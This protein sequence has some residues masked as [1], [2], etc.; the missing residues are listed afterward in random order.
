MYQIYDRGRNAAR[1]SIQE[2][3]GINKKIRPSES[4][5]ADARNLSAREYPALVTRE[6]REYITD[7]GRCISPSLCA[8]GDGNVAHFLQDDEGKH[9]AINGKK[10]F[11]LEPSGAIR[12]LVKM[13]AYLCVFP[14]GLVYNMVDKTVKFIEAS[15]DNMTDGP[16]TFYPS[17]FDGKIAN[18]SESAPTEAQVGDVWYNP[19]EEKSY[20]CTSVSDVWQSEEAVIYSNNMDLA[21][22]SIKPQYAVAVQMLSGGNALGTSG[23]LWSYNGGTYVNTGISVPISTKFPETAQN[24]DFAVI[25][26]PIG[27]KCGLY[28]FRIDRPNWTS[29]PQPYTRIELGTLDI[30]EKFYAGDVI[31]VGKYGYTRVLNSVEKADG[32]NGF[33]VVDHVGRVGT[34]YYAEEAVRISRN[35]PEGLANIIE[36]ANRL[37]GTDSEGREIYA[38]KLGDPLNWYAFSGLASDSYA[39]TVGSGGVFTGAVSYDGYPHFFKEGQI[40]KIYGS[41]PFRLYTLDCPGVEYGSAKSVAVLKGTV[42]YKGL[43][44]F[45]AYSGSY[46]QN[47]S[48]S[49]GKLSGIAPAATADNEAYYCAFDEKIYVFE[50]GVWHLHD[51]PN[52]EGHEFY[53]ETILDL[54]YTGRGVIAAFAAEDSEIGFGIS[55]P[56]TYLCKISGGLSGSMSGTM[57]AKKLV[58]KFSMPFGDYVH[59]GEARQGF[60][61]GSKNEFLALSVGEIFFVDDNT[62][63]VADITK[64]DESKTGVSFY[65]TDGTDISKRFTVG[66]EYTIYVYEN[67]PLLWHFETVKLGLGD[68]D[69]KYYSHFIF[70]YSAENPVEVFIKYDN[71][72][73]ASATLPAKTNIGSFAVTI[74]PHNTEYLSLLLMGKG[75]FSLISITKKIEGGKNP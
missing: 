74:I 32:H 62:Y 63:I 18:V 13:G 31:A 51:S 16:V 56:T 26:D 37:W 65:A 4:E 60:I 29:N 43:D 9:I 28:Q 6:E 72:E 49:L 52:T 24:G 21:F 69:D 46:P 66:Q 14:D 42:I 3:R 58:K 15:V 7:I 35:K 34:V 54:C 48:Q 30:S 20:L 41:Y 25:N 39:I 36:C 5:L 17:G 64:F 2:F 38:C 12:S 10:V 68:P 75:E 1:D 22:A 45:Y 27:K 8:L 67:T 44:A 53:P 19:K 70:K 73:T 40:L 50:N 23:E 59:E 33:I 11:K 47:I 57:R 71:G 61:Y 55:P